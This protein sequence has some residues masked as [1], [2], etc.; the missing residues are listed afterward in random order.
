M[1]TVETGFRMNM[2]TV[3]ESVDSVDLCLATLG[4][5]LMDTIITVTAMY[6][7]AGEDGE[8]YTGSSLTL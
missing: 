3:N 4:N 7:S 2:L 5:P 1:V 8:L 6:G